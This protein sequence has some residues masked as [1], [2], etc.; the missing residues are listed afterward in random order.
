LTGAALQEGTVNRTGCT[1]TW[2]GTLS[3][4]TVDCGGTVSTQACV[5]ALRR[6]GDKCP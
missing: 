1:G 2:D 3:T 4:M 6:A 5:A